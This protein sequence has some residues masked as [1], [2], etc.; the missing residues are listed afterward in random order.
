[1]SNYRVKN[2]D[3]FKAIGA[4]ADNRKNL[5]QNLG[6]DPEKDRQKLSYHILKLKEAGLIDEDENKKF[7]VLLNPEKIADKKSIVEVLGLIKSKSGPVMEEGFKEL[8]FLSAKFTITDESLYE[9]LIEALDNPVYEDF[10]DVIFKILNFIYVKIEG[11][12]FKR[13][14]LDT[15]N[16]KPDFF[17][18]FALDKNR[19]P[20]LRRSAVKSL[21]RI[22]QEGFIDVVFE[23]LLD[24]DENSFIQIDDMGEIYI[25]F[26]GSEILGGLRVLPKEKLEKV[27]KRAISE[28]KKNQ[29]DETTVKKI[30]FLLGEVRNALYS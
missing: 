27:K 21:L 14:F 28:L 23:I 3:V 7:K 10:K 5:L 16:N 12:D 11:T 9:F 30:G 29:D 25:D 18:Q 8:E 4:G 24:K 19:K 6:W 20:M 15:M 17:I 2:K 13:K 26:L 22:D 1:M